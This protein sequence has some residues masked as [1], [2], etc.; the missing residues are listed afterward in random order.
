[1]ILD[2]FRL[3]INGVKAKKLQVKRALSIIFTVVLISHMTD[4]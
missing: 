2:R 3:R 1:M 4:V